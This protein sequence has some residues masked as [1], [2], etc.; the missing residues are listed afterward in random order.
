MGSERIAGERREG[1]KIVGAGVGIGVGRRGEE[2]GN[3]AAGLEE[4]WWVEEDSTEIGL[5]EGNS[6]EKGRS[7]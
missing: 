3:S 4:R 6:D 2:E 1:D 5:E 7:L